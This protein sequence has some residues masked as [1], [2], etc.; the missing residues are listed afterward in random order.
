MCWQLGGSGQDV[1]ACQRDGMHKARAPF[2]VDCSNTQAFAALDACG[3][4]PDNSHVKAVVIGGGTGAPMSIRALLSLGVSTS[5]VVAMADDGGSTGHMRTVANATPPGDVRKCLAAMAADPN[6][7]L[8]RAFKT[9]FSFANDHTLGNLLLSALES[10]SS[11]FAEAIAICERL[12]ST[13]GHVYPSTLDHV[14]LAARTRSGQV[15][16]GQAAACHSPVAL[17]RVWL[18]AEQGGQDSIAPYGPAV[19]AILDADLVVLGPGS[20]YT[21]IIPNLLVPGVVDT[22]AQSSARVLFVCGLA[23]VQGET[24]GMSAKDHLQA[25]YDH[26]MTGL[27]DYVLVHSNRAL[28]P[29]TLGEGAAK[30]GRGSSAD[31]SPV[32][33]TYDDAVE[34]QKSG[35]VLLA[36]DLYDPAQPTWHS[37]AA[38]RNAMKEVMTL[39]RLPLR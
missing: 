8:T 24:L 23:D 5:V 15:L 20:L 16:H 32:R 6:D 22:L 33:I 17:E 2:D 21:S 18:T 3:P 27:V 37:P 25:L 12:L 14:N 36:H 13:R 29:E 1:S 11:G 7:P 28:R 19:R 31:F 38:L 10:A 26:G 9:R 39:C 4:V 34:I 35:P 30:Q